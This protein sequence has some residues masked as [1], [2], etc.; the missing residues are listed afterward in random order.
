MKCWQAGRDAGNCILAYS[1]HPSPIEQCR[2]GGLPPSACLLESIARLKLVPDDKA[3]L[4]PMPLP[5]Y[6]YL[7]RNRKTIAIKTTKPIRPQLTGQL[8]SKR[9]F[10]RKR[11]QLTAENRIHRTDLLSRK[12]FLQQV[13]CWRANDGS[14]DWHRMPTVGFHDRQFLITH[15]LFLSKRFVSGEENNTRMIFGQA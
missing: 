13:F 11:H 7:R 6:P 14:R 9:R 2:I 1:E 15:G 5:A 4:L 8:I 3:T 12:P 10:Q